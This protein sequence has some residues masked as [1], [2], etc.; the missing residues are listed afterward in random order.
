MAKVTWGIIGS[1]TGDVA[2]AVFVTGPQGIAVRSTHQY[3]PATR[4]AW[5]RTECPKAS[6][7]YCDALYT[8]KG[9]TARAP[10]K[11]AARKT[12]STGYRVWM[13]ECMACVQTGNR[14]P[15]TPSASGGHSTRW[16]IP[17]TT[18]PGLAVCGWVDGPPVSDVC[19]DM[20]P[21]CWL[22]PAIDCK[23]TD[24]P[25]PWA[26]F[27][28]LY[29]LYQEFPGLWSSGDLVPAGW[30]SLGLQCSMDTWTLDV[31][32]TP[33]PVGDVGQWSGD[34]A[35][36]C[37]TGAIV[38]HGDLAPAGPTPPPA[39]LSWQMIVPVD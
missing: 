31:Y 33:M 4:A 13:K 37:W 16:I 35:L 39:P 6:L 19:A 22:A 30:A 12:N 28:G 38:G 25:A 23:L 34:V 21:E 8:Q 36:G 11:L 27:A 24:I 9:P 14:P 3:R 26:G 1:A 10:W 15:D 17:G 18:L 32:L 20:P 7:R 29:R 2:D 5:R